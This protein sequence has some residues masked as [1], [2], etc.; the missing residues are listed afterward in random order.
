MPFSL[1]PR[2][3][4]QHYSEITPDWLRQQGITLLL[5]DLDFTLA[6]KKTRRPDQSLRDW[7]AALRNAGIG[8]MIVS[9]NRSGSR[10][11]EFCA[12][13]GVPY[14]GRAGKPSPRGLEAA[15][16]RAGADRVCTAMLG[17]KLLTDMLAANR[18]GVLALMVEPR[19]GAVTAWQKVLHA[20]QAPFKAVCR[21]RAEKNAGKKPTNG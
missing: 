10:V 11:T 1:T 15:M 4:F 18:C 6:A 12:D 14:Q 3:V 19:G 9:N 5:S 13:L 20:L 16:A 7:I 17:D 21:R 8:F 2:W